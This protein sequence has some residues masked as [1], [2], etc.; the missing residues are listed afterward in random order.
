M[1]T[2]TAGPVLIQQQTS[3]NFQTLA[4]TLIAFQHFKEHLMPHETDVEKYLDTCQ[5]SFWLRN[6]RMLSIKLLLSI[7]LDMKCQINMT[8][9]LRLEM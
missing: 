2:P 7:S 6:Q 1:P 3:K 4:K 8:L 9:L 5:R